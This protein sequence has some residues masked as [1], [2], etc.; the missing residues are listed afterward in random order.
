MLT[1]D[2]FDAPGRLVHGFSTRRDAKGQALNL[3]TEANAQDWGR[4]AQMLGV[5]DMG[6]AMMSQ[7]HGAQV[8]WADKAGVVGQA[9]AI[10]TRTPGL[11]LAVRTA[12][13]VPVL[14]AGSGAVGAIHAGWRGLATG[15]IP[16]AIAALKGTGPLQ[17]VV[18][19]SICVDC[20]EVSEAVV[21]GIAKWIPERSFVRRGG[22]RPHVDPGRAAVAQLEAAGVAHIAHIKVC[23]ACDE[24]LWSHRQSGPSAGRQ[25]GF[26]GRLC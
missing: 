1:D 14:V 6:I 5:S 24:R 8:L 3:G 10:L 22:V 2:S 17:A 25:A 9:D 13:C 26:V 16:A 15:V 4:A 7:V 12:D 18:G 11:L 20:Y 23:T 19:P 21:A